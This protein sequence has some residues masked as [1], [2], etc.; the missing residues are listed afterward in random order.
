MSAFL[1]LSAFNK[2]D[3]AD[4]ALWQ[5][6]LLKEILINYYQVLGLYQDNE[7]IIKKYIENQ[8]G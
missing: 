7:V 8:Q 5:S 3:F 1:E 6:G 2:I 4:D